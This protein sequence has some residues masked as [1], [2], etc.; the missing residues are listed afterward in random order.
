VTE[1][2]PEQRDRALKVEEFQGEVLVYDLESH[3]AHCLNGVAAQVW[4]LCDGTATVTDIARAV[5]LA[6]DAE[7]DEALI[8]QALTELSEA[9]LLTTPLPAPELDLSRRNALAKIGWAAAI[10]LVLS[11]AVP[12]P[13]YAQTAGPTGLPT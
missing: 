10:P 8:W 4:R 9:S 11:I 3:R 2:R 7:P 6:R 1:F 12:T 5:A 13:A